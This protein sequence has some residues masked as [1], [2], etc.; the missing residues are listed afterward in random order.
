MIKGV[1]QVIRKLADDD[2]TMVIVTHEMDF[3]EK[4]ADRIVFMADGVVVESGK[5]ADIIHNPSNPRTKAFISGL[6]FDKE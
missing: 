6:K 1:L 3:A 2:M 4:V 5:A